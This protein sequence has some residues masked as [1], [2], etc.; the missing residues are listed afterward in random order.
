VS[1]RPLISQHRGFTLVELLVVLLIVGLGIA[2]VTLTLGDNRSQQLVVDARRFANEMAG[3]IDGAVFDP[4]PWGVQIYR[5]GDSDDER[6][7]WRWLHFGDKGWQL[8]TPSALEA[9]GAFGRGVDAVLVVDGSEREIVPLP[10]P[11][12]ERQRESP[13]KPDLW[14]ASGEITP[15]ELQLRLDG[16]DT[17]AVVRGDALGRIVLELNGETKGL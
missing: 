16:G 8:E 4:Q 17:V 10:K 15:F 6:I 13:P 5:D 11:A 2:V 9:G 12:V 14:L 1:A 7:A 3:T